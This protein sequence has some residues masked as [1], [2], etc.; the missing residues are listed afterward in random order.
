[1]IDLQHS[2]TVA[3]GEVSAPSTSGPDISVVCGMEQDV[4]PPADPSAGGIVKNG[5]FEGT[6]LGIDWGGYMEGYVADQTFKHSGNQSI[7]ISNGGARQSVSLSAGAGS[8]ITIKGYSKAVG[9]SVG[10]WDY[11][12][13]ADAAYDDGGNLWGQIATFPGGTHDFT[14]GQKTFVVP[15]GKT[16]T[17]LNL[18]AMYRNDPISDGE[19][20]FDD[21]EVTVEAPLVENGGFEGSSI[22]DDWAGYM[23]GYT[24]DQTFHHSGDQSIKISNGGARQL[25]SLHAEAGSQVTIKGYSKAVSTSIGLWDYGIYTDVAYEDGSNL[26][27]QI[28]TFPG[29]THD[30]TLGQ[31]TFVVPAGK[32]VT[33]M[34][35][36]AMYRNDP[37][38]DGEVYFDDIEV[39]VEEPSTENK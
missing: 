2:L 29:G 18:Y 16:V 6:G 7:K 34:S 33:T 17:S 25:V 38:S 9:T 11:G 13:Y 23:D 37:I 3:A 26:W 21:V 10:L 12:I 36:Y 27:G 24:V 32:T 35:L 1:M 4:L 8:R 14:L 15:A 28:A 19:A 39:T 22:G 30:F 20:Y 5:G 31:K